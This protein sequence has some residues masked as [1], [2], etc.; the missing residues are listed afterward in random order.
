MGIYWAPIGSL[1][2]SFALV[3]ADMLPP[4]PPQENNPNILFFLFF[5]SSFP[6]KRWS[7]VKKKNIV[8]FK[9]Q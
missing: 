4:P 7:H 9:Y 2:F 6:I 8:W 5:V 1:Q 3:F